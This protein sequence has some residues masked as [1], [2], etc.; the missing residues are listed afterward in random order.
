M[1]NDIPD[2]DYGE[3]IVDENYSGNDTK[4]NVTSYVAGM[5][6]DDILEYANNAKT[7]EEAKVKTLR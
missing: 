5:T 7:E 6:F 1:S 2:P 3:V 4:R